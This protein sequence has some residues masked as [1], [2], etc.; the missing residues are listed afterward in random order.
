MDVIWLPRDVRTAFAPAGTLCLAWSWRTSLHGWPKRST[1]ARMEEDVCDGNK[2]AA[3]APACV[4]SER[5][6][7]SFVQQGLQ[8]QYKDAVA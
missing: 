8:R 7:E 2:Y 5:I 1:H 6:E 4:R 3:R